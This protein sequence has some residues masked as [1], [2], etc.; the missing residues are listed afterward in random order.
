MFDSTLEKL[1]FLHSH[2]VIDLHS[3]CAGSV[4]L[5]H[6]EVSAEKTVFTFDDFIN[7]PEANVAMLMLGAIYKV[8]IN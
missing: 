8:I 6:I 7:D 1:L 5:W 3:V 2:N 4:Y